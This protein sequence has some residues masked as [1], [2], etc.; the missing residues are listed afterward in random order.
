MRMRL[1][2]TMVLVSLAITTAVAAEPS[3]FQIISTAS[4]NGNEIGIC[5]SDSVDLRSATNAANYTLSD[6]NIL[7]T[8]AMVRPDSHSV[9]LKLSR[10]VAGY[11]FVLLIREV[12]DSRD[13]PLGGY[14][15]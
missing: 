15:Q 2:T 13:N 5:F 14:A 4:V 6:P 9:V 12:R 1:A 10:A 8:N 11:S 3:A 7:V